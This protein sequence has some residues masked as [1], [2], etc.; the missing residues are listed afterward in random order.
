MQ[1]HLDGKMIYVYLASRFSR[2]A[3]LRRIRRQLEAEN[4]GLTITVKARWLEN[5]RPENPTEEFF[6][7]TEGK[8]R[9]QQDF[10]DIAS[11]DILVADMTEGLGRRGGVMIE[12]GYAL[13]LGKKVILVG[14]NPILFGVF[15]NVFVKSF[16]DWQTAIDKF[17][18]FIQ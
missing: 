17:F 10:E 9:Y 4:E 11:S 2:Q 7:S 18:R 16:P 1:P 3:T 13:G 14:G 8:L 15:G 5:E 12:I 6:M